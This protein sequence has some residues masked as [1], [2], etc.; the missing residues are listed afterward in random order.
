MNRELKSKTKPH[1]QTP[2]RWELRLYVAGQLPKS[3][4]AFENLKKICEAHL[5]G[6]YHIEV[7]D[8]SENPQR[9]REDHILVVP[10]LVRK[11]PRPVQK[12]IGDLSNTA[13]VLRLLQEHVHV[14]AA[15]SARRPQAGRG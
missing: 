4:A 11:K 8:L 1:A 5:A 12:M 6:Q 3:L 13:R 2:D 14:P 7:I 9:A 10:T 15:R